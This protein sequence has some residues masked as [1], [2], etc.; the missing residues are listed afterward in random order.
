MRAFL[1]A[2]VALA[3]IAAAQ[4][5]LPQY[6]GNCVACTGPGYY[7]NI[8]GSC[9]NAAG[10]GESQCRYNTTQCYGT[11]R[12]CIPGTLPQYDNN[13]VA[14]T[15]AGYYCPG[16]GTCWQTVA[17]CQG[18]C[19]TTCYGSTSQCSGSVTPAPVSPSSPT[20]PQY[21]GNCVA[22]TGPGY[23]CPTAQTCWV[24]SADCN[25][26]CAGTTCYSGPSQC[27]ATPSPS[28]GT[29]PQYN[30]NCIACTGPGYYCPGNATCWSQYAQCNS[31]CAITC[32]SGPA[33][34][35]ATAAPGAG[36]LPQYDGNC[37][38]CTGPGYYCPSAATCWQTSSGCSSGCGGATCYS[39][40]A[41]CSSSPTSAPGLPSQGTL[42]Q[43]DNNCFACTGPGYYC[44]GNGTCWTAYAPCNSMCATTCYSGQSQCPQ[45]PAPSTLPSGGTLPQYDNNC[46]AC[47]G[48]G[49]YCPGNGTCWTAYAP[50]NSMCA[51]TCYSGTSQCPATNA[52]AS[53][54][55]GTLP[56][57]DG[58]CVAC[59]GPGYYCPSAATCWQ[60]SSGCSS[61]CGG[62]TCYGAPSACNQRPLKKRA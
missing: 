29:L 47:T 36:T 18:G 5:P 37:V 3:T 30:G 42:P 22:C 34:C 61:G 59:T 26:N 15:G 23:Y 55:G 62:A 32:Y 9:W 27:S 20:Y 31:N 52:P 28:S 51:Q 19:A 53:P 25:N 58:N 8:D 13:C 56:Q 49:Y 33:Q 50:C 40:P 7:C 21:N 41:Q 24:L 45:T 57:Y 35:P 12:Q 10:C 1:L 4:V 11:P 39:A 2:A 43:Y 17:A 48:P 60:T 6:N 16:N 44:P 46:I 14:C 38:A 54:S